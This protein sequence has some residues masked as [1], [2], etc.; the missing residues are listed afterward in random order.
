[1]G[2][3][4][5]IISCGG[6]GTYW[7]SAFKSGVTE[8]EAGGGI[9][10]DIRCRKDFGVQHEY[11]LK[12]LSTVTSAPNEN[13]IIC[14]AGFKT[15]GSYANEPELVGFGSPK[16][17]NLSAEHGTVFLNKPNKFPNIGERI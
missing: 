10:C 7:I 11:S 17:L 15:F 2:I 16:S 13:R 8:I 6:T 5:E 4:V 9:F 3:S 1:M 12:V 14:D